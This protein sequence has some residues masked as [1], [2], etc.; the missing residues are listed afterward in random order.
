MVLDRAR[1]NAPGRVR[2]GDAKLVR[3]STIAST[4][5]IL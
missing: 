4:A 3:V 5:I 2:E 1:V